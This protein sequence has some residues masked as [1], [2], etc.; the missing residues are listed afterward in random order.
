MHENGS[1]TTYFG[2]IVEHNVHNSSIN[3][4]NPVIVI[5]TDTGTVLKCGDSLTSNIKE[6]YETAIKGY[7]S[8]GFQ[9][10]ADALK[11]I[12]FDRYN[13][14]LDIDGICTLINYIRNSIGA[15]KM[16]KLL[17]MNE[18]GIKQEVERLQSI[19]F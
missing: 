15:D 14:I 6:W 7:L 5:D 4:N 18:D 3:M 9:D 16:K 10:C 12:Y 19:G 17:S 11:I 8:M 1:L 2:M 13:G